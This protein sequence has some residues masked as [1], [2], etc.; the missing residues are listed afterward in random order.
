MNDLK[1][2]LPLSLKTLMSIQQQKAFKHA[3][4][5]LLFSLG[6]DMS[7]RLKR[8]QMLCPLIVTPP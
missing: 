3:L 7:S 5:V 4:V 1:D 8:D 6:V 2:A